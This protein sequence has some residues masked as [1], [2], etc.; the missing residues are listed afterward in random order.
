MTNEEILLSEVAL[1]GQSAE[2]VERMQ[3]LEECRI[4][5]DMEIEQPEYLFRMHDK[6]CFPRGEL[7]GVQG[8]M[9]SGKTFFCSILMALCMK[10]EVM[11]MTRNRPTGLRLMWIDTEQS[12][13]STQKILK[14]RLRQMIGAEHLPMEQLE[15]FN[16]RARS[17]QERLPLVETAVKRFRPELVVFDGIRDCVDD[18]NDYQLANDVITRLTQIAS[19]HTPSEGDEKQEQWPPCCIVCVLH[20]N[21]SDDDKSLRGALGTE[22]GNKDWELFEVTKD[23]D[24]MIFSVTQRA[25]REIDIREPLKFFVNEK[26]LPEVLNA[27][28]EWKYQNM[29]QLIRQP[30]KEA[31]KNE[32][33]SWNLK[34]IFEHLLGGSLMRSRPVYESVRNIIHCRMENVSNYLNEA[35]NSG[36]I[37]RE[38]RGPREVYYG[39]SSLRQDIPQ[40][41][42]LDMIG[43]ENSPF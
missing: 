26:G 1:A 20:E 3:V 7:V 23:S 2:T 17:W 4:T 25:T 6:D 10:R 40:E 30:Q 5:P 31:F 11:T 32:D 22:L 21:K 29:M 18:I 36:I 24:T 39:L 8:K 16:L 28:N 38:E 27:Q 34:E 41:G 19:G 15:V 37:Y 35:V 12:R 33:G 42:T 43:N 14:N 9:K 13:M